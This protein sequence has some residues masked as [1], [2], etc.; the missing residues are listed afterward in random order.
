M[1]YNLHEMYSSRCFILP[2]DKIWSICSLITDWGLVSLYRLWTSQVWTKWPL[3]ARDNVVFQNYH[4]N[5]SLLRLCAYS[6]GLTRSFAVD[7]GI[8]F[9]NGDY[10]RLCLRI[11][12]NGERQ[13]QGNEKTVLLSC[14]H[15]SC[16]SKHIKSVILL[17]CHFFNIRCILHL[18]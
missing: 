11:R 5:M 12:S 8:R 7:R 6:A 4:D 15:L 10:C 1:K 3:S 2:Q 13:I 16:P 17:Y 18:R 14:C 9:L